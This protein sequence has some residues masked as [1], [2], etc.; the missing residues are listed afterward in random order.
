MAIVGGTSADTN[1][2]KWWKN[3]ASEVPKWSS[4]R[5]ILLLQ[6]L[7]AA[8]EQ[9]VFP[10]NK[11]EDTFGTLLLICPPPLFW[12]KGEIAEWVLCASHDDI[13]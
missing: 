6:L 1:K 10:L 4:G 7:S 5:A 9:V 13:I 11:Q 2:F 8:I 3:H 12:V